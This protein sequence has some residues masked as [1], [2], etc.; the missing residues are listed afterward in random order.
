MSNPKPEKKD[1]NG[2]PPTWK[3]LA[4]VN[5]LP[6][7]EPNPMVHA[8]GIDPQRRTCGQCS[9]LVN[10]GGYRCQRRGMGVTHRK[11][12]HACRLIVEVVIPDDRED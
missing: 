8:V 10:V 12:W 4:I 7:P 3:R 2:L 1:P 11:S 5:D 6:A 9:T